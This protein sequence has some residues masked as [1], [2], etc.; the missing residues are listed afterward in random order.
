MSKELRTYKKVDSL[1][2]D[3][4][5]KCVG[6]RVLDGYPK[7]YPEDDFVEDQ[8]VVLTAED[9]TEIE[10]CRWHEVDM[11]LIDISVDKEKFDMTHDISFEEYCGT[12]GIHTENVLVNG[13]KYMYNYAGETHGNY[14]I[15]YYMDLDD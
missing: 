1:F 3:M 10:V 12:M 5:E 7:A 4:L 15:Q 6:S 14:R 9:G 13:V 2:D 11:H 8:V